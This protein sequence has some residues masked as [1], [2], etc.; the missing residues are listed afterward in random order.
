M[1]ENAVSPELAVVRL[2]QLFD[3]AFPIGSFAHS[4]GLETY[5]QNGLDQH[6]L[7]DLL[8]AQLELGFGR[9]DAAACVLAFRAM[10]AAALDEL[11]CT[12]SAWKPVPGA[13]QTSL[14]LGRRLLLLVRRLYPKEVDLVLD[15]PHQ[16]VVMGAVGRRLGL[17]EAQLALSFVHSSLTAQLA[18]ATRTVALSPEAAQ[19][20]LS[21]LHP[22]VVAAAERVRADP[23]GNLFSATP[24]LDVRAHQQ[25]FLYT[26]LFQS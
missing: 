24:A 21:D 10:D 12:L 11:S 6:G 7:R 20:I 9:L 1:T 13:R 8:A 2:L 26:R 18:A 4:S 15:E 14:K 23:E 19:E 22:N 25:A 3:S 5:A 17:S 16:A